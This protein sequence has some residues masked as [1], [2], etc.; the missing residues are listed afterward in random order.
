MNHFTP[1]HFNS[2][3]NQ[4]RHYRVIMVARP[5]GGG[6]HKP[7][8]IIDPVSRETIEDYDTYLAAIIAAIEFYYYD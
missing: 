3:H 7:Y 8:R 6:K 1:T 4:P 2:T 5:P